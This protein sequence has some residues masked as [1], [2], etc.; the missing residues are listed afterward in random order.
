[1]D[2]LPPSSKVE[3]I[4]YNQTE[5]IIN[6]TV[7]DIA[8]Y[9]CNNGVGVNKVE[10]YYAYSTDGEN[11][12]EWQLYAVNNSLITHPDGISDW[13]LTFTASQIGW[14]RFISIA[15]DC[16]GNVEDFVAYDAECYV[17]LSISISFGKPK[18]GEWISLT[19]PINIT[20]S[21]PSNI[22]YRIY[23][24]KSWH[25]SPGS[26]AGNNGNF[27][28][29]T[30]NFTLGQHACRHGVCFIEFYGD[31]TTLMNCSIMLDTSP[32]LTF[33]S[34]PFFVPHPINIECSAY[35]EGSGISHVEF[36][37]QYSYDNKS[38]SNWS[39]GNV[40]YIA[41]YQWNFSMDIGFYRICSIGV[42]NVENEEDIVAKDLLRVFTPDFN[43]DGIVNV[44]DLVI[45]AVNFG[46]SDAKYDIDGNG[47]ADVSDASII[48]NYWT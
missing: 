47:K 11:F 27:Y 4:P 34:T 23:N 31:G 36:Y 14:Y 2:C 19:T 38:W 44:Q 32:P 5:A 12:G 45:L 6:I 18:Y 35:D 43:E 26:G 48:L 13:H 25:P 9:G 30:G 29:Y 7:A 39:F 17:N 3:E 33:V 28:I 15:Y 46:I 37:Y 20:A 8:D 41:P 40:D 16:V 24:N 10:V 22:Y 21:N 1:V 42:D